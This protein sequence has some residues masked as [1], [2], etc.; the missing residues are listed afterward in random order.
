MSLGRAGAPNHI[1]QS[2]SLTLRVVAVR[3]RQRHVPEAQAVLQQGP[4][5]GAADVGGGVEHGDEDRGV[6]ALGFWCEVGF[7][8]ING[9]GGGVVQKKKL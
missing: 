2:L 8:L 1:Y 3:L 5:L 4:A 9:G 6:V 7:G